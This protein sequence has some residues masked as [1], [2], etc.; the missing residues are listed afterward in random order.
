MRRLRLVLYALFIIVAAVF[1]IDQYTRMKDRDK[2]APVI[3]DDLEYIEVS[4]GASDADLLQGLHAEDNVDGDVTDSLLVVS[5]SKF[6][7]RGLVKVNYAAFDSHN[8]VA[9][10]TRRVRYVDYIS[11]RFS[12]SQP[13]RYLNRSGYSVLTG[14]HAVDVFDGDITNRIRAITA[15]S[16]IGTNVTLEVTNTAGDTASILIN[17]LADD[18]DS[19]NTP[20]PG[21]TTYIMYTSV[22]VEPALRENIRGIWRNGKTTDFDQMDEDAPYSSDMVMIDDSEVDYYTPGTYPVIYTLQSGGYSRGS[23]YMYLIVEEY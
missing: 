2:T 4:V 16:N 11:P 23:S 22:G 1:G 9:T 21:L 20:S 10:Y 17:L 6:L 15:N 19:Y 3:T 7:S 14:V 18:S 12:A 8:N 5:R 13:F